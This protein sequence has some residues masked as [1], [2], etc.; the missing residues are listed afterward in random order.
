[1]SQKKTPFQSK[2]II[3]GVTQELTPAQILNS[4]CESA[5]C[6]RADACEGTVVDESLDGH[7]PSFDYDSGKIDEY[8]KIVSSSRRVFPLCFSGEY[9]RCRI[10]QALTGALL[11]SGKFKL[12]DITLDACWKWSDARIGNMAAFYSSVEQAGDYLDSLDIKLNSYSFSS[13]STCDVEFI[14]NVS[15]RIAVPSKLVADP[16][17]WIIYIPFDTS[18]YKLGGSLLSQELGDVPGGAV[19]IQDPDYFQD[20]FEVVRE[21]VEDGILL[22][23]APVC[24]GGLLGSLKKMISGNV[25]TTIDISDIARSCMGADSVNILFSEVPGVIVQIKD[26]DFDYIDA[27][28]LLQDV[29]Y[30]PLGHPEIGRSGIRIKRESKAGIHGILESLI[31]NF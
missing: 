13:S 8:L 27:E 6:A 3:D 7:L 14:P 9:T 30:Y 10:A 23:A 19:Q 29:A 11:K 15:S 22:S 16:K 24:D 18:E 1:M 28:L 26:P 20:C 12:E 21:L 2:F 4:V 17:S 31:Q 5:S 25:G